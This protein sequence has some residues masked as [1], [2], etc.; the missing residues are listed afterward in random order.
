MTRLTVSVCGVSSSRTV[1]TREIAELDRTSPWCLVSVIENI[2]RD[3]ACP[4]LVLGEMIFGD[5]LGKVGELFEW[6]GGR[7]R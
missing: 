5:R 7:L 4:A 3:E 2:L 1:R 6:G